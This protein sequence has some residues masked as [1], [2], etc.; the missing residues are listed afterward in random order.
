[1]V[2]YSLGAKSSTG[3]Y[4]I[5]ALDCTGVVVDEVTDVSDDRTALENLIRTFNEN[6]L[7]LPCF[8]STVQ[9]LAGVLI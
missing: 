4:S 8:Q 6:H 7:L 1:M 9:C 3:T 5:V 2:H